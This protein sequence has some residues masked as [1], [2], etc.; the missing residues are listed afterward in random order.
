MASSGSSLSDR[1]F[2][3]PPDMKAQA[4]VVASMVRE[5]ARRAEF[6]FSAVAQVLQEAARRAELESRAIAQVGTHI[7]QVRSLRQIGWIP[8]PALP[9]RELAGS[10]TDPIALSDIVQR[11]IQNNSENIYSNLAVRFAEY[12]LDGHAKALCDS[13]I[14]AHRLQLF[15]L[16]VPAIF[17]EIEYCARDS[18]GSGKG[19]RGKKVIDNFVQKIY[20]LPVSSFHWSQLEV[21]LL[22]EEYIYKPTEIVITDG[23]IPHRHASQHGLSRYN[24]SQTC[25]NAIFILDFF[26]RAREVIRD[27]SRV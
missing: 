24:D 17:S 26:L 9:L 20:R 23:T 12:N 19:R 21:L 22:M 6:Q 18:L 14:K 2:V 25:L 5:A 13:V 27:L 16:I 4:D 11:Y 7:V 8:H 10:E 3:M 1:L 15:P